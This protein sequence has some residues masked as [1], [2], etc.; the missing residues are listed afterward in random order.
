MSCQMTHAVTCHFMSCQMTHSNVSLL[1]SQAFADFPIWLIE[2]RSTSDLVLAGLAVFTPG[3]ESGLTG[4]C[5][6]TI[7]FIIGYTIAHLLLVVLAVFYYWSGV[8]AFACQPTTRCGRRR[9]YWSSR[10]A[11]KTAAGT[12]IS[13]RQLNDSQHKGK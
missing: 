9:C 10:V 5:S 2:F 11:Q 7:G 4:H 6:F 8:W 13:D 12:D 3:V 1:K